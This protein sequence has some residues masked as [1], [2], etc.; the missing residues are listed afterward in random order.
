VLVQAG[1]LVGAE[2][3]VGV[4]VRC[5]VDVALLE[6]DLHVHAV[7][8]RLGQGHERHPVA[9]QPRLD[10]AP[11]RAPGRIVHVDF[12]DDADR[13]AVPVDNVPPAPVGDVVEVEP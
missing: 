5:V 9:E 1:L 8:G 6:G 10:P 11:L 12:G 13:V 7:Q 4:D 2:V 3:A